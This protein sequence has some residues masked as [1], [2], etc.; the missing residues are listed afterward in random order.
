MTYL[1][2]VVSYETGEVVK[3]IV[4]TSERGAD[5]IERGLNINLNHEKYY[6]RQALAA[7]EN[8]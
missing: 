5:R 7:T 4:C 6:T 1:V 8:I 2:E 3:S